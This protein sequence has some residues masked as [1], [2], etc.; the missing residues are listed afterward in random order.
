MTP[1]W[2]LR[3][4][5][6][7]VG[8]GLCALVLV[9]AIAPDAARAQPDE[10]APEVSGTAGF[11]ALARVD[12]ALSGLALRGG[13]AVLTVALSQPVPYRVLHLDA[14][15]RIAVEFREAQFDAAAL[16]AFAPAGPVTGV[17]AV[18]P[19][20]GWTRLEL[21]L[22]EPLGL[23]AA[24][25]DTRVRGGA[26]GAVLQL[27]LLPVTRD[28]FA[29]RAALSAAVL[30]EAPAAVAIPPAQG[31]ARGERPIRVMLD[32]GHGGVDPGAER[33]GL[34]EADLVLGF[35][36]ELAEALVRAGGFTV[37]LTRTE[38]VFVP[39]ETRVRLAHE[40]RADVFLSIH[41]DALDGGGAS[42]ATVYTLADEASDAASAALAERHDRD[43]LLSGVD[44]RA[45][46]DLVAGVLMDLARR[47]TD[48]RTDRLADALVAGL[49]ASG[50]RMHSR[51]RLEA[52]F[53]V[54]KAADIPSVLIELGFLS[55]A[56]DRANLTDLAWRATAASAIVS[57]LQTWAVADAAEAGLL[58]R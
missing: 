6:R 9:A 33:D 30:P 3:G 1:R 10:A 38:D 19:R 42:G 27:R 12:P 14:P 36:R 18:V 5:V 55:S 49:A 11:G 31:R 44:L 35:A 52:G 34:R 39:L 45:Q 2:W 37:A 26:D 56:R 50:V 4:V 51:P 47:D 48:P 7:T 29:R 58:R 23:D 57:A 41:A 43:D 21:A 53:S 15:R 25:L 13:G 20:P 32:P 22:S 46:D 24:R 54:L 17:A 28:D 40:G 16:A 8:A